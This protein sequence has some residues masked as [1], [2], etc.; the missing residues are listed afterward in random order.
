LEHTAAAKVKFDPLKSK[1]QSA[2]VTGV[3]IN[4]TNHFSQ[5]I[6]YQKHRLLIVHLEAT[7]FTN[8]YTNM[9]IYFLFGTLK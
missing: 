1:G 4:Q 5:K 2:E 8:F 6:H 7:N 9:T 3:I